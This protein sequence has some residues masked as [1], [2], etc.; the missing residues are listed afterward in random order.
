MSSV[1]VRECFDQLSEVISHYK[2]NN[3]QHEY[4]QRCIKQDIAF[5]SQVFNKLQMK[6]E[7]IRMNRQFQTYIDKLKPLLK[8][9]H[10]QRNILEN[11]IKLHKASKCFTVESKKLSIQ[12]I[13]QA[14]GLKCVEGDD[15]KSYISFD[16]NE[17]YLEVSFGQSSDFKTE[18]T[19]V[20]LVTE[21][22]PEDQPDIADT[23]DEQDFPAFQDHLKGLIS[24]FNIPLEPRVRP[25][26][27][28]ALRSLES[29]LVA[30]SGGT[31][32][33][34][35]DSVNMTS[36]GHVIKSRG[37]LG[38]KILYFHNNFLVDKDNSV[39]EKVKVKLE[40]GV[41]VQE[42]ECESVCIGVECSNTNQL[43]TQCLF[44]R[45]NE[46]K[47]LSLKVNSEYVE[48]TF[49][50][51]LSKPIVMTV[52]K[53][54]SLLKKL[55]NNSLIKEEAVSTT[56][57]NLLLTNAGLN[58]VQ[59]NKDKILK[60]EKL[61][62]TYYLLNTGN[63]KAVEIHRIPFSHPSQV[64]A[65]IS[66]LRQQT[67]Y[68]RLLLSC[69]DKPTPVKPTTISS[70]PTPKSS[71]HPKITV[72][73]TLQPGSSMEFVFAH[74]EQAQLCV[75]NIDVSVPQT[76]NLTQTRSQTVVEVSTVD[77][78]KTGIL[79]NV[80]SKYLS[81]PLTLHSLL[82]IL[83]HHHKNNIKPVKFKQ[84]P[85]FMS[86]DYDLGVVKVASSPPPITPS[87]VKC[88]PM[89][90]LSEYTPAPP[91]VGPMPTP[92]PM[93]QGHMPS[94]SSPFGPDSLK[95]IPSPPDIIAQKRKRPVG[96]DGDEAL[97]KKPTKLVKICD[98]VV[99]SIPVL[100][101]MGGLSNTIRHPMRPIGPPSL[102]PAPI[103]SSSPQ[104]GLGIIP[105]LSPA[106]RMTRAPNQSGVPTLQSGVPSLQ[107][108]VPT[109]QAGMSIKSEQGDHE[110]G[111]E[112][113]DNNT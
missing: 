75:M 101:P 39:K 103:H 47:Q 76:S 10:V 108:S 50:M 99:P 77:T 9:E 105:C 55:G 85:P 94:M 102:K 98:S 13:C 24:I 83:S 29:D 48:A 8:A 73:I 17:F 28:A 67:V 35:A 23:L 12:H 6:M 25:I 95:P 16:A 41:E 97:L 53:M 56:F 64:S 91:D 4:S 78:L 71:S 109:L 113:N 92:P 72:D 106:P 65:I 7:E 43:P 49:V 36:T 74:P 79:S 86:T 40:S 44:L 52:F 96:C 57:L 88:E 21:G 54:N 107:S 45:Q 15:M 87:V 81:V 104:T 3:T 62:H 59:Q 19:K 110:L 46:F 14:L 18:G 93:S 100:S 22:K 32:I 26:L 27:F 82:R 1:T 70:S 37:G 112:G 58:D 63:E 2:N 66:T 61:N 33:P 5:V 89:S 42:G 60:Y 84:E 34:T 80:A 11:K 51:K 68:N 38:I 90:S 30:M 31:D 111:G 20:S 69:H